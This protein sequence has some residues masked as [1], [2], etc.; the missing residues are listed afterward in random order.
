MHYKNIMKDPELAPL[1][2]IGLGNEL[3]RLCQ[4]IRYI[5]GTYTYFFV[6]LSSIPKDQKMTFG[7]LVCDYKPKKSGKISVQAHSR[8]RQTRV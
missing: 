3:G 6:E 5:A 2:E 4:V 7:K 1:F 8:G